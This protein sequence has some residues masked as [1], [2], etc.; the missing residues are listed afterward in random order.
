ML[1]DDISEEMA[2]GERETEASARACWS[3]LRVTVEKGMY[4]SKIM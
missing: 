3:D 4:W 1:Y 2:S